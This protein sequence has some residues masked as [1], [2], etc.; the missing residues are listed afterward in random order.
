[1]GVKLITIYLFMLL[2]LAATSVRV[3][4]MN[5]FLGID[6]PGEPGYE[7]LQD[8]L[9]RINA[10]VVSL[11]EVRVQDTTGTPSN[12]DRLAS[13]LGYS[14]IL[15]PSGTDFDSM[16]EVII[17]SKFP[18]SSTD[19]IASPS[20]SRD[21]TRVHPVAVVDVPGTNDDLTIIGLHLKCCFDPDDFFRRAIEIERI[22]FYL[23]DQGLDGSD[24]IIVM[25]DYN[26]LGTDMRYTESDFQNFTTLPATYDLGNDISFPVLYF[27]DPTSYFTAY[28]LLNPM[29]LQQNGTTDSTFQSGSVL[30]YMLISQAL[31]DRGPLLEVYNSAR[32]ASFPGLPKSGN[33]L[34][35]ST[36]ETA[37]DH[38]PIF[39]D[40]DLDS[41]LPLN[42][43]I[44]TSILAEGGASTPLTVTLPA[45]APQPVTVLLSSSDTT[46]AMPA[47]MTLTFPPGTTSQTTSL[48]TKPD[49]IID[50]SQQITLMV[51]ASGYLSDEE[52]LTVLDTDTARYDLSAIGVTVTE[53]FTGFAGE[54]TPAKWSVTGLN[55][56]GID[57]GSSTADGLRS[58]GNDASFGIQTG[59]QTAITGA[60]R[61]TTGE[62]ISTLQISYDAE[63]WHS[64]F[65]GSI[66]RWEIEVL[67][68]NVP[69]LT[70]TSDD[71]LASGAILN[72]TSQTISTTLNGLNINPNEDFQIVFTATPGM[73]GSGGSD[74]IFLNEL[75]YDNTG[76]DTGE[77][78]EIVVGSEFSGNINDVDIVLYNGGSGNSYGVH[79]LST[80]TLDNTAASGHRIYSKAI[81]GIQNGGS[82]GIAII[83]DGT[84]LQFLSYEGTLTAMS[85][86]ASGITSTDIGVSQSSA[87]QAGQGS[88]GL[89]GAGSGPGDFTWTR[90][91]GPFTKG[92]LNN[93]QS[94]NASVQNQGIAFDNLQVTPFR[95]IELPRITIHANFTLTFFSQN[96]VTY[97]IQTSPDLDNW[98]PFQTIS[99]TGGIISIDVSSMDTKKFFRVGIN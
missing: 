87:Q 22:K 89:T 98:T 47:L 59:T 12:L 83:H 69:T 62:I 26:L 38:F 68:A 70:F 21:I 1:M 24:H 30:D 96:G 25:G 49:K 84:V 32:E 43:T 7:A 81:S 35:A 46:E 2:P 58:Y 88:I 19:S 10:D 72:G 31:L 67:S 33:A 28:P 50:G 18:F 64:A 56:L 15:I 51:S 34:P 77:F 20:G 39:G 27:S 66:D 61:N 41:G 79:E 99:G 63:Q 5:V 91:S 23:D 55:W 94:F 60:F 65:E 36:S 73:P 4:T 71:S 54:Q 57:D 52:T 45:A 74:A 53:D 11:Q 6:T 76:T 13:A 44:G 48:L 9:G 92:S 75:H 16:N 90:F 8:V 97:H 37:S 78:I 85:G 86:P 42:L 95:Q 3:A 80:F 82:D 29:P 14:H 40:F 93:G 17:M